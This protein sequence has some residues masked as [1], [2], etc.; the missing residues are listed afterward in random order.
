MFL[1]ECKNCGVRKFDF[2]ISEKIPEDQELKPYKKLYNIPCTCSK[3]KYMEMEV[4]PI[5]TLECYDSFIQRLDEWRYKFDPVLSRQLACQIV[6][7]ACT[8]EN[9][10]G[11]TENQITLDKVRDITFSNIFAEYY[12]DEK[13]YET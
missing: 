3:L 10:D 7:D 4:K 9:S 11:E 12:K 2:Q 6:L 1:I 8:L 13:V 5:E